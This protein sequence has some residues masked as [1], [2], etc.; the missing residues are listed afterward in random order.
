MTPA[1]TTTATIARTA[2]RMRA[3]RFTG[4]A[5]VARGLVRSQGALLLPGTSD[6]VANRAMIE[7][8]RGL[9]PVLQA[10]LAGAFTWAVT[11]LG[12]ALVL[13]TRRMS[14]A[15]LDAMLGFAA[16]VMIAASFWSL[17]VPA[18]DMAAA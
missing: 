5:R 2:S 6:D 9:D 11:A 8:F 3:T 4:G 16:G 7:T 14:D 15:L 1:Y 18:I 13:V 12:A 17:L 10:L